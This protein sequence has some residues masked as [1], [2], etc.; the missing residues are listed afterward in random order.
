[1]QQSVPAP[2]RK[3]RQRRAWCKF[4][5]MYGDKLRYHCALTGFSR[6][7]VT[8]QRFWRNWLLY[9]GLR[10]GQNDESSYDRGSGSWL[11]FLRMFSDLAGIPQSFCL[12]HVR[13][14]ATFHLLFDWKSSSRVSFHLDYWLRMLASSKLV[15]RDSQ[16]CWLLQTGLFV[17]ADETRPTPLSTGC[18]GGF[19]L[20]LLV[21]DYTAF[22][23]WWI[24]CR[25]GRLSKRSLRRHITFRY[26][27]SGQGEYW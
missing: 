15:W 24:R 16:L 12:V 2:I 14:A 17:W 10:G 26:V 6:L 25:A 1:M 7:V 27:T 18:C 20:L 23:V 13:Y 8:C 9:M 21:G 19:F 3:T 11:S 4:R 5:H 22:R